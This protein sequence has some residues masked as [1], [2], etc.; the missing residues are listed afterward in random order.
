MLH[1]VLGFG[2]RMGRLEY[3]LCS[4]VFAFLI[5]LVAIALFFGLA[6]LFA[7]P[8]GGRASA[9]SPALLLTVG[10]L[11][12]PFYLWFSLAFQAKRFRDMG[13]NPVYVLPGWIAAQVIDRMVAFAVPTLALGPGSGTLLGTLLSLA[14]GGCLLFWPSAPST[15][16]NWEDYHWGSPDHDPDPGRA[17][18]AVRTP[19]PAATWNPAPAPAPSGFGRRGL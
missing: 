13:W 11:V 19:R 10:A 16:D 9:T 2:G 14:M 15:V 4:I 3:F 7:T 1:N 8:G 17:R 5:V 12:L 6:P 18:E